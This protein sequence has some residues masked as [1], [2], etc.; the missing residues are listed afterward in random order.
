MPTTD[1]S[2]PFRSTIGCDRLAATP[3]VAEGAAGVR[4]ARGPRR[5]GHTA[6]TPVIFDHGRA[7]RC[8]SRPVVGNRFEVAVNR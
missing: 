5:C 8:R 1:R 4:P 2:S 3:G 6:G 7:D